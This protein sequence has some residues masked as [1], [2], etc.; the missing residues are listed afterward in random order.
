MGNIIEQDRLAQGP[1][2]STKPS[3]RKIRTDEYDRA[4]ARSVV[5]I[6]QVPTSLQPHPEE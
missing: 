4:A 1:T 3:S 6:R 2:A 5:A